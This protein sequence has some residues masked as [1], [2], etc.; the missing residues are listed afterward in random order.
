MTG[1]EQEVQTSLC[2]VCGIDGTIVDI[3]DDGTEAIYCQRHAPDYLKAIVRATSEWMGPRGTRRFFR[4][5]RT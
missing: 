3:E 1:S 4:R 2:A 5:H